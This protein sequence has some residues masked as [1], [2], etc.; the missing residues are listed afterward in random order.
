[1]EAASAVAPNLRTLLVMR[2]LFGIA[3]GGEWGIGASLVM[4]S[5]PPGTRGVVSGWLQEGYAVGYL[6]AAGAYGLL[7]SHIG[8]RGMFLLG[9][10]P[11]GL[12]LYIR[13]GVK[14]SPA[15]ERMRAERVTKG[16]GS[17]LAPMLKAL[18]RNARLLVIVVLLMA[19]FNFY[20][21]GTQDLFPTFLETQRH[22]S[23]S[24]TSLL[25]IIASVGAIAGGIAFGAWSQRIGRRRAII[26]AVLLTL[27]LIPL[28]VGTTSLVA[29][30][31]G[32]FLIQFSVQGAWGVIPAHLNELSPEEVRGTFPGFAYQLGNLLAA[33]TSVLQAKFAEAHGNNYAWALAGVAGV[34]AVIICL[35]T[36]FGP[37]RR[38]AVLT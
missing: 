9:I 13:L 1:M 18:T 2:A 33:Q 10:V 35:I 30:G 16:V 27:P 12:A 8:W 3:M 22:L 28:W 7:F 34:G 29:M 19:A 26:I 17:S 6:L 14:E 11:A 21:H 24:L 38:D 5:I 20:S 4:E 15:W 32:A 25:G 23:H 31:F 36:A 37:E